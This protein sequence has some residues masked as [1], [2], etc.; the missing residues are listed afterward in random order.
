MFALAWS[1]YRGAVVPT[2]RGV[3]SVPPVEVVP[4]HVHVYQTCD[5]D[6]QCVASYD[7]SC[8]VLHVRV[9]C[10]GDDAPADLS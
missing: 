7:C 10:E 3:P 4:L 1:G 2:A 6:E 8:H 9:C 5:H